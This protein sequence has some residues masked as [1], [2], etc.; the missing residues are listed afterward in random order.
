MKRIWARLVA[1]LAL[2]L[3][4]VLQAVGW[5]LYLSLPRLS[6]AMAV[7]GIEADVVIERDRFAIPTIR[8]ASERDAYFAVGFVHAQDRLWQMEMVRR[9]AQGRLAEVLG[10]QALELDR[11]MRTLGLAEKAREDFA[12]LSPRSRELLEAYARGVNAAMAQLWLW[13]PEFLLLGAAPEPWRPEDSVAY[14][15]LLALELEGEWREELLRA[16]VRALLGERALSELFPRLSPPGEMREAR[17][18]I[19]GLGEGVLAA[20]PPAAASGS[21]AWAVAPSRSRSGGALLAGDPHL[22]LTA[23]GFWYLLRI[24]TPE[25]GAAGATLPPLPTVVIGRNRKVAWTFTAA[26]AD[27]QDLFLERIRPGDPDQVRTPAGWRPLVRRSERI[28]LRGGGE[29]VEEVRLAPNGPVLG[30]VRGRFAGGRPGRFLVALGWPVLRE[31][32][33]TLDAGFAMVRA[34][35]LEAFLQAL[36]RFD[37]PVQ[38]LVYAARDG[39]IGLRVV[40]RVPRR[41]GRDGSLPREGWNP[42][43]AWAG[44]LAPGDLPDIRDPA[45]GFVVNANEPVRDPRTASIL[46]HPR[47]DFR[48]RRIRELLANAPIQ[49][50]QSTMRI[51]L[52]QRSALAARLAVWMD[53]AFAR[54]G[55]AEMAGWDRV[56]RPNASEPLLFAAWLDSLQE[57]MLQDELGP[58]FSAYR[59]LSRGPLAAWAERGTS[60]WCDDVRTAAVEDCATIAA[61]ALERARARIRSLG[62]KG[63]RWGE[64]HAARFLHQPFSE[65]SALRPWFE[66]A[67]PKGGGPSTVDVAYHREGE[68]FRTTAAAGLRL[69]VDWGEPEAIYVVAATG[70]SGHP[71]SPHYRDLTRLWAAGAYVRMRAEGEGGPVRYRLRLRPAR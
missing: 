22:R 18:W 54:R 2:S 44:T 41:N 39:R 70:Q 59:P 37:A 10:E 32:M 36:E 65:L 11:F 62:G 43:H 49:D 19:E 30:T 68:S 21:N 28:R 26:H 58:L 7:A 9:L 67:A 20:V 42:E 5:A 1:G 38:N 29:V 31:P 53:A 4:L 50:V 66:I 56:M 48:A 8:A 23:P 13:P 17:A 40:G 27:S 25:F 46:V 61:R 63:L 69:I 51:Q 55:G 16:R 34:D 12:R 15:A 14:A 24:E 60:P 71:F 52:D 33:R 6:G 47:E 3:L 64:V 57:E 35:S 45:D